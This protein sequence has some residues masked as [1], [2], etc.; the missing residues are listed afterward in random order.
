[1]HEIQ[2]HFIFEP[3]HAPEK[4]I[5][6]YKNDMI[7]NKMSWSAAALND[8]YVHSN[9]KHNTREDTQIKHKHETYRK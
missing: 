6:R 7:G 8:T 1:M 4:Q 9:I 5:K 3:I 2:F